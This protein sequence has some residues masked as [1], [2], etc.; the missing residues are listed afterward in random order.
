MTIVVGSKS[1]GSHLGPGTKSLW[2]KNI[3]DLWKSVVLDDI[4]VGKTCED[5]F[6]EVDTGEV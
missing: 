4:L 6:S 5:C 3:R 2:R 1:A